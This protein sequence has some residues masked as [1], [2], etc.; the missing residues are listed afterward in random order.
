MANVPTDLPWP[1]MEGMMKLSWRTRLPRG[2]RG[3]RP[4]PRAAQGAAATV[5]SPEGTVFHQL[6]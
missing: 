1:E 6:M 5:P 2:A 4:H 3:W